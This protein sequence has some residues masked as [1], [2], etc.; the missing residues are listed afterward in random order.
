MVTSNYPFDG[1][2]NVGTFV[3]S[4]ANEWADQGDSV[5]V[6]A[7]L[8]LYSNQT[9]EVVWRHPTWQGDGMPTVSRPGYMSY[10]SVRVGPISTHDW[11][12]RSFDRAVRRAATR[13]ARP[14]DLVYSHFLFPAGWSGLRL[15]RSLGCRAVVA[16]GESGFDFAESMQGRARIAETVCGFDGILCVSDENAQIIVERYGADPSRVE[17]IPNAVDTERFKPR[18]RLEM[19][20]KRG[21]PRDATILSFVGNFIDRKG[22]LRVLEAMN[23]VA[24]LY[25][26]FLGEGPE[27]PSGPRVLHAG[28]V[29]NSEVS[30]WLSATDFFVLPTLAEGSP[31][32]VIEAMA[33]G[34]PIVSSD[35]L[36]LRETVDEKS[37][38]L[39]DPMDHTAIASALEL[40][41]N[42]SERRERMG[43]RAMELGR[44][45]TL[46]SRA[47]RIRDWLRTV[48]HAR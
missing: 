24:G 31:N 20:R 30:E 35:I 29:P 45:T 17:V 16:L 6:I 34:L 9:K 33:C 27:K 22:P 37:A 19:R 2:P 43:V 21:L 39:V 41:S 13:L 42:D 1:H 12:T 5:E 10:S 40:L 36:S 47:H 8:P 44:R 46:A 38:I 28:P 23:Q 26:I 4:L 18:D 11:T 7:P 32:A 3:A 25:G 15:A 48:E 14:F